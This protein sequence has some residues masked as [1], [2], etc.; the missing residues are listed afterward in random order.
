MK[1][2]KV[3][4][5]LADYV[6]TDPVTDDV[7]NIVITNTVKDDDGVEHTITLA[8]YTY[9]NI[10]SEML[11]NYAEWQYTMCII[12]SVY[13]NHNDELANFVSEWQNYKSNMMDNWRRICIAY[14]MDY[15]PIHNYDRVEDGTNN[16]KNNA[17]ASN[18]STNTFEQLSNSTVTHDYNPTSN[19]ASITGVTSEFYST[20]YDDTTVPKLTGQNITKGKEETTTN[21][22]KT[23][24]TYGSTATTDS[25]GSS[26]HHL[27]VRGN[28]GV[29]T[30]Q[31]M[32][33]AEYNL[34]K[35]NLL[36]HIIRGFAE[37]ALSYAPDCEDDD[38]CYFLYL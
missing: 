23:E 19:P 1:Q 30:S 38:D 8:S 32:I 29:T 6:P 35:L 22:G 11:R 3:Y 18:N 2:F 17:N 25:N 37:Y 4:E 34:R 31:E 26:D 20:T 28:V 14:S 7:F 36:Q 16:T 10:I 5:L 21:G 33:M 15:N 24:T 9:D 13:T 12:D 27:E